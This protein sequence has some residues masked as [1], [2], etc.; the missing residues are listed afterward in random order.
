MPE[1]EKATGELRVLQKLNNYEFAFEADI[2]RDGPVQGGRWVFNNI[3][4]NYKTFLGR[5]V[6]VAYVGRKIGD[7]HNSS[8]VTDFATGNSYR[9]F[10]G[11]TAER[12]VGTISEDEGDLS[13]VEMDGHSWVR[14]RGRLWSYY[15]PELVD[16]IVRTG[17]M[18]VSIEADVYDIR[19]EDGREVYDN[20]EA[21]GLTVLGDDVD[22]AVPGANIR[23]LAEMQDEFE[24]MKLRVAALVKEDEDSTTKPKTMNEKDVSKHMIFTKQQIKALQER[25]EGYRVLA[26]IQKDGYIRVML[27]RAKDHTFCTVKLES[28]NAEVNEDD[29][30][31]CGATVQMETE[32]GDNLCAEAGDVICEEAECAEKECK[33]LASERDALAEQVKELTSQLTAM[34]EFE[35]KRR[36][37]AAK[38]HATATLE[39]FN[40]N[41]DEKV[42]VKV[43]ESI[44]ADADAGHY[45]N[46]MD[47]EGAWIGLS[48]VEKDVKALCADAVSEIDARLA[49]S[50][51]GKFVWE[52]MGS[53]K[54]ASDDGSPEALLSRL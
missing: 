23:A 18:D 10:T 24:S 27:L 29:V 45:T 53:G 34:R 22:P 36:V 31:V 14:V 11:A 51:R 52:G 32:E 12:I 47:A 42:D 4:E 17:R 13:I 3:E 20:W 15:A 49:A 25:F 5:P 33:A 28:E 43:L 38:D 35:Q 41:R 30:S 2:L 40:A 6:L 46:I 39:K 54:P 26:A 16:K 21:L 48:A 7:G 37:Q 50:K 9:S 19:T 44:V 8:E 1:M